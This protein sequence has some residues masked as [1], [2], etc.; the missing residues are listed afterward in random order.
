MVNGVPE[1]FSSEESK[2]QAMLA[3]ILIAL[4]DSQNS[5][6]DML[7]VAT[8]Q[9]MA[10]VGAKCGSVLTSPIEAQN[11]IDAVFASSNPEFTPSG[12]RITAIASFDQ[13]DKLF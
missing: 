11:L 4:T 1:G 8:A 12:K 10:A 13:I 7:A 2:V 6:P 3:D 5:L 9:K